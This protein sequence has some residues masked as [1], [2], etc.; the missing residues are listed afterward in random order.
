M[1]NSLQHHTYFDEAG[2]LQEKDI[3]L[4]GVVRVY[5]NKEEYLEIRSA[6]IGRGV[7]IILAGDG[8]SKLFV[9]PAVANRIEVRAIRREGLYETHEI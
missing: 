2:N 8:K 9:A 5:I 6:S 4:E 7:D 3:P 1:S